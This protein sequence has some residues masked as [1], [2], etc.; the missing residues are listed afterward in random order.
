M[1]RKLPARYRKIVFAL[2]MSLTTSLLVSAVILWRHGVSA[3]AFPGLWLEAFTGAWPV[4]FISI[5][6]I[7]PRLDRL[8]NHLVD[9]A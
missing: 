4:V 1:T 3:Q 5:L 2:L 9:S 7:A 8:L 6:L